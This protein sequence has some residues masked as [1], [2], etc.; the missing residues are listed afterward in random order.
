MVVDTPEIHT[1]YAQLPR[2][3]HA[4]QA[5]KCGTV[6]S[7]ARVAGRYEAAHAAYLT[8]KGP[9][10]NTNLLGTRQ[11]VGKRTNEN[12]GDRCRPVQTI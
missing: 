1:P 4:Q 12:D 10:T 3:A 8:W 5:A 2:R 9:D 11:F 6:H 7:R